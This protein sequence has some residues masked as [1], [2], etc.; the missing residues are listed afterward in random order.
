[1]PINVPK[2]L[3]IVK[4]KVPKKA[5]NLTDC[6]TMDDI[7]SDLLPSFCKKYEIEYKYIDNCFNLGIIEAR[8]CFIR[9]MQNLESTNE[10]LHDYIVEHEIGDPD[11]FMFWCE[12]KFILF[13]L[14]EIGIRF[15]NFHTKRYCTCRN[16]MIM[17]SNHINYDFPLRL[18]YLKLCD[19]PYLSYQKIYNNIVKIETKEKEFKLLHEELVSKE[20]IHYEIK[21]KGRYVHIREVDPWDYDDLEDIEINL[22]ESFPGYE[23]IANYF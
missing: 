16:Y 2:K 4:H 13:R 1:M 18:S 19:N 12:M 10:V 8:Q 5:L 14:D 22:R 7:D 15:F 17:I 21:W 11:E 23:I 9:F 6:K 20:V 3:R